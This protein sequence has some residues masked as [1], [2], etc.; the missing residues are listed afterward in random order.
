MRKKVSEVQN[1]L[2]RIKEITVSKENEIKYRRNVALDYHEQLRE[3]I[4]EKKR[5]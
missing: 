3:Y 4:E 5:H 1:T 2:L